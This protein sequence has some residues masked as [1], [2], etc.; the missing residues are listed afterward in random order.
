ML[1]AGASSTRDELVVF[2]CFAGLQPSG[3]AIDGQWTT[4]GQ[5]ANKD[6][7]REDP[8]SFTTGAY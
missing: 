8:H 1:T 7:G 2:A 5:L 4:G 3:S 6:Q